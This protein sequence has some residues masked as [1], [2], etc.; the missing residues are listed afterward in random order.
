MDDYD[1]KFCEFINRIKPESYIPD[2]EK[3]IYHYTSPSGFKGIVENTALRFSDRN[4]LNDYSEGTYVM[5]LCIDNIMSIVPDDKKFREQFLEACKLR[6]ENPQKDTF[7]VHQCS[8]SKDEDN[9]ALW[10]YY[11]KGDNIQ[12]YNLCFDSKDL[13]DSLIMESALESGNIPVIWKGDVIYDT[14]EQILFVKKIIQDYFDFAESDNHV[15]DGFTISYLVDKLM[16]FGIFFKN[17][18]FKVENEYRVVLD[19]YFD[20]SNGD[21]MAIKSKQK[22]YEKNGLLIPYVD[23]KFKPEA[24]RNICISPTLDLNTNENSI[25]RATLKSF[26]HISRSKAVKQSRIPVRY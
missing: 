15:N 23:I 18:C 5:Q 12:G 25:Y 24:L 6:R 7:Y 1:N 26:P 22:F 17:E 20:K 8:F 21:F 16:I 9:L 4:F 13:G 2:S 14:N 3:L 10:N 19:L 11:T